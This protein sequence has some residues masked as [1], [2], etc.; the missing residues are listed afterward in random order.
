M[1]FWFTILLVSVV[2]LLVSDVAIHLIYS[3]MAMHRFE[4]LPTF[5]VLPPP[6]NAPPM[7]NIRFSTT[8]NLELTGGI[9][10][11]E[12]GQ[13][14]GVVVFCPET[15][16]S[17]DTVMNYAE[18][19]VDAGFAVLSFSFRNQA[20]SQSLPSY[21][22]NYWV[23]EY[24]VQDVHAAL[25]FVQAQPQ[26]QGLP[27]G[28]MGVS[29]GAGA[30]VAAGATRPEVSFVWAQ[31]TFSTRKLT[32]HH[33]KKFM[34]SLV[35]RFGKLVPAW[36]VR[37]TIRFMMPI[38]ELRNRCRLVDLESLMPLWND[39]NMLLVSGARDTYV[40]PSLSTELCELTGHSPAESQWIVPQ[41]KHNLERAAAPR[42][43]DL[44]IVQYFQQMLPVRQTAAPRKTKIA[45][46]AS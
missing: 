31:G 28:L 36:H 3:V 46:S 25:D 35:G 41:A 16:G 12:D 11:P 9:Y 20:P 18:A 38:I 24:E 7:E 44:R 17:F 42:E 45:N 15:G 2:L 29:R 8:D 27:I 4:T 26:F 23:T 19:L 39:R 5:R 43:F 32:L 13:P 33:A 34:Q 40:P 6:E 22:S 14:Q 37:T 10:F 21:R 1:S 30:A